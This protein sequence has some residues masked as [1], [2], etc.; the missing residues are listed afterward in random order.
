MFSVM[1][2]KFT[3]QRLVAFAHRNFDRRWQWFCFCDFKLT[4]FILINN[5]G[6]EPLQKMRNVNEIFIL[7]LKNKLKCF[8]NTVEH[9]HIKWH[10][11]TINFYLLEFCP[12]VVLSGFQ[13]LRCFNLSLYPEPRKLAWLIA[14]N[15]FFELPLSAKGNRKHRRRCPVSIITSNLSNALR[16]ST[17]FSS[18]ININTDNIK[19]Q[20]ERSWYLWLNDAEMED[21][22]RGLP[23]KSDR[24]ARRK[25]WKFSFFGRGSDLRCSLLRSRM[26]APGRW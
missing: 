1:N 8:L 10:T 21:H 20:V 12:S 22:R 23:Y 15:Y 13:F 18:A 19:R 4:A 16:V 11:L 2:C 3:R 7:K 26:W 17:A 6:R 24:G 5:Y 9:A 14:V 25:F